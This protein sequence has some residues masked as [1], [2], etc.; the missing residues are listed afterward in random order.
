MTWK[1]FKKKVEEKGVE[2]LDYI[3][4]MDFSGDFDLV[5][6]RIIRQNGE[7]VFEVYDG[8]NYD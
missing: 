2:D 1:E 8:N 6:N 4:F 3:L 5:V 7:A